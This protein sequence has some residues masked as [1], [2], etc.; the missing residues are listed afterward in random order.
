M[1]LKELTIKEHQN[2]ERQNFARLLMSG[3][4]PEKVYLSYIVNQHACYTALE[5]HT[6][7][8]LPD[9]RLKRAKKIQND[10][11]E[12]KQSSI[13]KSIWDLTARNLITK[14]TKN[15]IEHVQNNIHTESD[16]IAHI[17]V[18]Y[19][20]DLRG[21]QMISKKVPGKGQYYQFEAPE[22]LASSIYRILND[23]MAEEAKK[24]FAFATELFIEMYQWY[25]DEQKE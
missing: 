8:K 22:E 2:A 25:L 7:F 21:G 18:R 4:I 3:Q 5:N 9:D 23:D 17:Y 20:G 12:L 24:V 16:F 14:S 13:G 6:K 10:I 1:S 15:Y 11:D 19:L